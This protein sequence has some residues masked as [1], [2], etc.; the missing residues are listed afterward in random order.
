MPFPT[1]IFQ[2][3]V[4]RDLHTLHDFADNT[5]SDN[6][7]DLHWLIFNTYP[8]LEQFFDKKKNYQIKDEEALHNFV[9]QTYDLK[10]KNM[11]QAMT[12]HQKLW[13]KVAP[14]FFSLVDKLF[15]GRKWPEGKYI[16]FGTIWGMYPR[17]LEDKTFQIPF[18]PRIPK[19]IPIIIAH[20][21]LHFMFY[22]YFYEHYSKLP[23]SQ[24]DFFVWN[25]SEIF[26]IV[27]QNSPKWVECFGLRSP[28]YPEHE[29]IIGKISSKRPNNDSWDLDDLI[30]V[31]MKEVQNDKTLT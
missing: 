1:I 12:E 18:W 30:G 6:D 3:S 29:N 9:R 5:E 20:E 26:N 14:Q 7:R 31:I 27:I 11:A 8:Q 17:F 25:V 21:L 2:Q 24:D 28:G 19:S 23:K 4:E 16:A 15:H 13:E 10:E 22:D